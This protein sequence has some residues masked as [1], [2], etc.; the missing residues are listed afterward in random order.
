TIDGGNTWQLGSGVTVSFT[1]TQ[2]QPTTG[3]IGNPF[4]LHPQNKN[5]AFILAGSTLYRSLDKGE[6]WTSLQGSIPGGSCHSFFVN[7]LDTN[8]MIAAKGSGGAGRIIKSTNYGANWTDIFNPISL[9]SYGMPLEADPNNPN[10]LYLGPDNL[11]MRKST[12]FG[13]TW[14]NLSGG[15]S[16]GIFRSPCDVV[17]QFENPNTIFVGDGTT[18]SGSGKFWKSINGGFN[19]TL[20]NTVSGSEIPMIANN[21]LN[22]NLVYH[23]TWSS[24]SFWKSTDMGSNFV[25]LSQSG[26]LWATDVAKDDPN[27]VAYDN[28]GSSCYISTNG[29]LNFITTNVGS[30]PAAGILFFDKGNLLIQHGGGVYKMNIIYN[31]PTITANHQISSEIPNDFNISQNYPNPFNPS[32]KISYGLP[33]TGF[34]KIIVYN[35]LG[36]EMQTLVNQELRAGS[37]EAVWDASEFPSGIYFYSLYSNGERIDTK[38]MILMK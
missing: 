1:W 36:K 28:Y 8:I 2:K 18:G 3:N 32:T 22:I 34:V 15:E 13:L 27:T 12:D 30:S 10:T 4:C 38:K 17:I 37:Y 21:S 6:T 31:V 7:A 20:I 25:S 24:G 11:A 9:T 23:S 16:G 29:G 26:S 5:G 33:M 19:W 35:V 14:S